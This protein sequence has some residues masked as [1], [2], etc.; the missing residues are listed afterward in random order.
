MRAAA[1]P[2]WLVASSAR[3]FLTHRSDGIHTAADPNPFGLFQLSAIPDGRR[4]A[5]P[6]LGNP[7]GPRDQGTGDPLLIDQCIEK[8]GRKS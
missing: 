7:D 3:D 2:G 5:A 1:R 8:P 6:S 4:A